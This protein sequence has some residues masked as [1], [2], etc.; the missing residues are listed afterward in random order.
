MVSWAMV[1]HIAEMLTALPGFMAGFIAGL[2][3]GALAAKFGA[4]NMAAGFV[5]IGV[6]VATFAGVNIWRLR[7]GSR[8]PHSS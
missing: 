4:S 3:A 8:L 1:D 5:G 2:V 7:R 6:F